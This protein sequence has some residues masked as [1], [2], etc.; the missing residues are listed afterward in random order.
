[1]SGAKQHSL[2][3]I[4]RWKWYGMV[5]SV[6]VTS[7]LITTD[8]QSASTPSYKPTHGRIVIKTGEKSGTYYK[9]GQD[10]KKMGK[11]HGYEVTIHPSKGSLDNS[12]S[13]VNDDSIDIAII[14]SDVPEWVSNRL[15]NNTRPG[16][17]LRKFLVKI[18]YLFPLFNEELH[19]LSHKNI[20]TI[21]DLN[22]RTISVGSAYSGT[23]LTVSHIFQKLGLNFKADH[24]PFDKAIAKLNNRELDAVAIVAGYPIPFLQTLK[25]DNIHLIPVSTDA[26]Y[27]RYII[28]DIPAGTYPWQNKHVKTIA[29][30]ALLVTF[31]YDKKTKKCKMLSRFSDL[32]QDHLPELK[33]N[34]HQKWHYVDFGYVN[35]HTRN[36]LKSPCA[37]QYY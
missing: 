11:E 33:E 37:T 4:G 34:G 5:I 28:T 16:H 12:L 21:D 18:K 9:I 24:T 8:S 36:F 32:I 7:W 6:I 30:K 2:T 3:T 31:D 20:K 17:V 25:S 13:I 19:I 14:Q 22:D 23:F 26:L 29:V 35:F 10:L 1:M 15:K 27:N